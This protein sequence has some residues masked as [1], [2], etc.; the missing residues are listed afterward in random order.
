MQTLIPDRI[1]ATMGLL[2]LAVWMPPIGGLDIFHFNEYFFTPRPIA[3][4]LVL[5]ALERMLAGRVLAALLLLAGG[6]LMHP[7]M[8]FGGLLLFL[9]WALFRYVPG[10]WLVGLGW[11]GRRRDPDSS[12]GAVARAP[13]IRTNGF[14][15]A[16]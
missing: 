14:R 5:F 10:R 13:P 1:A 8:G 3:I 12:A 2:F 4:A 15:L 11:C 7:L 9:F 6:L 16:F